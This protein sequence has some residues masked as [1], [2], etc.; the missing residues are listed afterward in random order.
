MK[1]MKEPEY[2]FPEDIEALVEKEPKKRTVTMRLFTEEG[3]NIGDGEND[4][5]SKASDSP[6]GR[7]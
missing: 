3:E 6:A 2:I 5:T 1:D 4:N 7:F